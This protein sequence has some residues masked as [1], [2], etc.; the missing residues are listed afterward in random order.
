[1]AY[2]GGCR[3]ADAPGGGKLGVEEQCAFEFNRSQDLGKHVHVSSLAIA[4]VRNKNA[5]RLIKSSARHKS[6]SR[7]G[8]RAARVRRQVLKKT[9]TRNTGGFM[10]RRAELLADRIEEGAADLAA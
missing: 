8:T 3:R 7:S 1:M 5:G 10:S 4:G 2:R 6:H 9:V